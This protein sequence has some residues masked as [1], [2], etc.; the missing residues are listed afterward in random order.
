MIHKRVRRKRML[1][2]KI[3]RMI[4]DTVFA[5]IIASSAGALPTAVH[6]QQ[7]NT[8]SPGQV[9]IGMEISYPPFES[10]DGDKVVGFDPEFMAALGRQMKLTPSFVD[11]KFTG[12]ILGLGAG[13]FDMVISGM[14]INEGRLKQADGIPYVN[15][16]ASILVNKDGSIMPKTEKDLCGV[17][18]GLEQGTLYVVN[19][20]KLSS[21]Y[22]EPNGKPAVSISEFPT[23]PEVS[24]ALLSKNVEA[25]VELSST[26]QLFVK[27]SNGR[28]IVSSQELLYSQNLGMYFK[29]GS[30]PLEDAVGEA[31]KVIRDNGEYAALVKKYDLSPVTDQ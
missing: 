8:L 4:R 9:T 19:L 24:Q 11:T 2:T 28:I 5:S 12:L 27:K 3:S 1:D 26:A 20:K 13:H 16:G 17:K 31:F 21:E 30:K 23:A 22:C 10:W 25:Q 18:V 6:A 7:L 14:F 15:T 29:K